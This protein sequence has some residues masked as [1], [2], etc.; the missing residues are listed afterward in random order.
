[1]ALQ[2]QS[3]IS[4]MFRAIAY[5]NFRLYFFGQGTSL[6]GSWIQQIA[7]SW[8]VYRLTDSALMLGLI[9]F[10]TQIPSLFLSPVAGVLIDRWP[11]RR[12][13]LATQSLAMAQAFALAALTFSGSIVPWHVLVLS[14]FI[15]CVYAVDTPARQ[16][17]LLD[18]VES[19]AVL[20]NAI[21]L[22]AMVFNSVRLVAPLIAGWLIARV[23][24]G[25]CFL[26]NGIS[27]LAVL[28]SLMVIR[29]R[30]EQIQAPK[31]DL[32]N[33]LKVGFDYVS[34]VRPIR[35]VLMLL[36]LFNLMG[37]SF[38]V[39]MP[40]F[41]KSVL[42]GGP[43]TLGQLM[44]AIGF[45]ALAA[46]LF[47]AGRREVASLSRGLPASV[48]LF[49]LAF[50][51]FSLSHT[52]W[53]SLIMLGVVGFT[54]MTHMLLANTTLQH[55]A[56]DDKRGRVISYYT[57]AMEGIGPLG[58]LLAGGLAGS[59]GPTPALIMGS[60]AC[61]IVAFLFDRYF[62]KGVTVSK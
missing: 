15:G 14:G 35:S 11:R 53:L 55:L 60:S 47:M 9:V 16:A 28:V 2:L 8:L 39:L 31:S 25:P 51:V 30:A 52:L 37:F 38:V 32:W 50:I 48:G 20:G 1:M 44:A 46:T 57:V 17:F 29:I 24:E 41:A 43:S 7:M 33:E 59:V 45:G 12:V 4:P 58:G 21:A 36:S 56:E 62:P 10:V 3:R 5:K 61:L 54:V 27:F 6:M 18:I 49:A 34:G 22:N 40:V 19:K 42:G 26:I 13:L 23:G